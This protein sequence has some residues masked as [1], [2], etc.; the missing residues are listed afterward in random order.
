MRILHPPLT[1]L[2]ALALLLL[3]PSAARAQLG[4]P[5]P[6]EKARVRIGPI[7]FTPT[8]SLR[9]LGWDTNVFNTA[10]NKLKDFAVTPAG[11]IDWWMRLGRAR[12]NG[13][14]DFSY[15]YW[16][17]YKT[18]GGFNQSHSLNFEVPLSRFKPYIGGS[19]LNTND[20]V[21]Y[22]IDARAR[23]TETA[24][25]GGV[26]TRLS[27][28]T[29]IDLYGRYVQFRYIG[30]E[31]F[32]GSTLAEQ[33][34]KKVTAAGATLRYSLT[35][36]TTLTLNGDWSDERYD[37]AVTRDNTSFRIVP[38]VSFKPAALLN[39]SATVGYRKLNMLNINIPDFSG[40]VASVDLS[41]VLLGRTRFGLNVGRD[42]LFSF[43]TL[44]PYY[45]QTSVGG[46][47]R[48]GLGRGFDI[49]ARGYTANLDYQT[50]TKADSLLKGRVDKIIS[51]GGGVGYKLTD[52]SRIAFYVDE[53]QRTSPTLSFRG[54][55]GLRYGFAITYGL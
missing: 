53:Y 2:L 33:F 17:T 11:T 55:N 40:V 4:E 22:E 51:Y 45:L 9:Q 5:D 26:V 27:G 1:A 14:D 23:H 18:Q 20:R 48:F 36:L 28:R 34:N 6:W 25:Q 31:T 43:E 37:E 29:G 41:Y 52:G 12:L 3:A 39:G 15:A 10:D 24:G 42:I 47:I 16:A 44:Q 7:A 35:P 46:S 19:Y 50:S 13:K 32:L 49:E 38:G 30:D 21:G 54:Y 8:V